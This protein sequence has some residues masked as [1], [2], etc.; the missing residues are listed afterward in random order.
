VLR[1]HRLFSGRTRRTLTDIH[2]PPLTLLAE[3]RLLNPAMAVTGDAVSLHAYELAVSM[4]LRAG[5]AHYSPVLEQLYFWNDL[6]DRTRR[7]LRAAFTGLDLP[8]QTR[9]I[10][11]DR[12]GYF[13][14]THRAPLPRPA[15]PTIAAALRLVGIPLLL[16]FR[17]DNRQER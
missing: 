4:L 3:Y 10:D 8:W 7:T 14:C 9:R 1:D 12:H 13:H 17:L 5:Q 2:A 15:Y 6:Q 16:R 11:M